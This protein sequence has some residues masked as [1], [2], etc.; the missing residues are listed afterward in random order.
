MGKS[1]NQKGVKARVL[2]ALAAANGGNVNLD[3]LAARVKAPRRQITQDVCDLITLGF[4]T[5]TTKGVYCATKAGR[6]AAVNGYNFGP[7][8]PN[9]GRVRPDLD[10]FRARVWR[11]LRGGRPINTSEIVT[12][13]TRPGESQAADNAHKYLRALKTAGLIIELPRRSKADSATSNGHKNW[14]LVK[15]TGPLSPTYNAA[16]RRLTDHN[17]GTQYPLD[18]ATRRAS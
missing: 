11:A 8:G 14:L 18:M 7:K 3:D 4:A 17:T 10:S 12:L 6:S 13:A 15:N 5:R 2:D 16:L 9:T 1:S